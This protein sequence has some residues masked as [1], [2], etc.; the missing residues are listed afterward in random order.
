MFKVT[1]KA[2]GSLERCKSRLVVKGFNQKYGINFEEI[3]SN[4]IK[5]NTVRCIIALAASRRWPI[6]QLDVN[7]AFLHGYL[8]EEV[9]MKFFEILSHLYPSNKLCKLINLY[10]VYDMHHGNGLLNYLRNCCCKVTLNPSMIIVYFI[11]KLTFIWLSLS[12]MLM[13]LSSVITIWMLLLL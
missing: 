5:M 2:D 7:N 4:F 1:L 9:Y 6:Y 13:T 10:M 12:C 11:R 8:N 3:F